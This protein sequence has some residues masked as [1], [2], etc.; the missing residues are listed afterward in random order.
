MKG[1]ICQNITTKD[2]K[3]NICILGYKLVPFL[4]LCFRGSGP[5]KQ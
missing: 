1:V 2:L 3:L 4:F 5:F